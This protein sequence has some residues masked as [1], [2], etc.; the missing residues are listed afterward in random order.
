MTLTVGSTAE[1]NNTAY[2]GPSPLSLA[3]EF[4]HGNSADSVLNSLLGQTAALVSSLKRRAELMLLLRQCAETL[5][6]GV[7]PDEELLTQLHGVL[8][9]FGVQAQGA[10]LSLEEMESWYAQLQA[11]QEREMEVFETIKSKADG[12][13]LQLQRFIDVSHQ[14]LIQL[15][16]APETY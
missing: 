2:D 3:L 14:L 5:D 12:S 15:S 1:A 4:L 10:G 13:A 7:T 16:G 9:S 6:I 11:D 8:G